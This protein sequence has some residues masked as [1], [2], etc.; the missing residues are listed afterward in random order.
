MNDS[1][2]FLI[3]QL[4]KIGDVLIST[5]LCETLK[6]NYPNAQVDYAVYPYATSVTENNPF[7][8]NL[9]VM[10]KKIN[11]AYFFK[12][13]KILKFLRKQKYDYV[14]DV[15]GTPKSIRLAN[16]C[17]AKKIVGKYFSKK[18]SKKYDIRIK[19]DDEKFLKDNPCCMSIK[20][21]LYLLSF[22]NKQLTYSTKLDIH[23]KAEEFEKGTKL[24]KESGIDFN[25]NMFFFSIASSTPKKTSWPL[26]YFA[27]LIDFCIEKYDVNIVMT[28]PEKEDT[29]REQYLKKK[30][31]NKNRLFIIKN[32]TLRN[33]AAIMSHCVLFVGNDSGP[34]H[35]AVAMSMPSIAIFSP[36]INY[37]DWHYCEDKH[38]AIHIQEV[39]G[40]NSTEYENLLKKQT[41]EK[42]QELYKCIKPDLLKIK[43][44]KL[45]LNV[46][47]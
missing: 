23:L 36:A 13:H 12:V 24:L 45:F 40:L 18:R 7:I 27:E 43:I 10:P 14:I 22:L 5:T 31:L 16:N 8:D 37:I 44:D 1:P 19:F 30:I 6:R 34:K 9:V 11:I 47:N 38:I 2:R 42:T 25:Q 17:H 21:R 29:Q 26:D 4:R 32:T 3:I 41:L 46:C 20:N 35:V 39:L 33:S 28:S 15:L